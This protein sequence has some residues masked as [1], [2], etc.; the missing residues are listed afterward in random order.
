MDG[1]VF[2][3]QISKGMGCLNFCGDYLNHCR[4]ICS[5]QLDHIKVSRR[6]ADWA[7]RGSV[8]VVCVL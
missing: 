2:S 3:D 7:A 4:N 8:G 1:H 5:W 6:G